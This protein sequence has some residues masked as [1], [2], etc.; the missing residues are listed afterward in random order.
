MANFFER[1]E[2]LRSERAK[3]YREKTNR[4]LK[5]AAIAAICVSIALMPLTVLLLDDVTDRT[6]LLLRG[7]IG[8]FAVLFVVLVAILEYKVN[9]AYFMD[10]SGKN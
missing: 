5:Y 7:L 6:L 10:K 3:Y 8:L 2:Q 4:R 1:S 9:K